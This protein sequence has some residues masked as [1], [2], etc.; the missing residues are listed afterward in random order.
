M[1]RGVIAAPGI[2]RPLEQGF[3][4]ERSISKEELRYY[5]L[6]WDKVVIPGNNLVYIAVPEEEELIAS[7]AIVRPR[8][9]YQGTYQGDQVTYA[10]LEC[11]TLVAERL[12]QDKTVDWV[13]HQVG[14]SLALPPNFAS[15]RDTIRVALTNILPVPDAEI[16]V[17][18]ILKFKQN[19]KDELIELHDSLDELYFEVLNS[20]DKGLATNKAV[21]KFQSAIQNLY[22]TSSEGFKKTRKYDLSV[23][24]NLNGKDIIA[25]ASAGALIDFFGGGFSI[26]IATVIGAVVS[27]IKINAKASYTFEPAK[28]NTKL[29]Y[30]SKASI[31]DIIK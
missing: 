26:P 8:V 30:I 1:D 21:L 25:G 9:Q 14:D 3:M 23:E 10:I 22:K 31:E 27:M 19:R 16:P 29:S 4:M 7:H 5:I 28:E 2:I 24:L 20:P 12:M 15:Q 11:Q 17:Q 18:E 13:L 6:Y